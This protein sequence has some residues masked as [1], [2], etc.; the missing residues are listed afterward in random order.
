MPI[1]LLAAQVEVEGR[2]A[3]PLLLHLARKLLKVALAKEHGAFMVYCVGIAI[4]IE[5]GRMDRDTTRSQRVQAVL[6]ESQALF[7]RTQVLQAAC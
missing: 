2:Y 6:D 7:D 3:V 1:Q 4:A 5:L